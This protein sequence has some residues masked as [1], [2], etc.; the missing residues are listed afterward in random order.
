MYGLIAKAPMRTMVRRN[1][2]SILAN[3]YAQKPNTGQE[4]DEA[5]EAA[6]EESDESR[7]SMG[8][9]KSATRQMPPPSGDKA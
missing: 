4:T 3:L 7:R 1:V 9:D 2:V 5:E 6:P 8:A